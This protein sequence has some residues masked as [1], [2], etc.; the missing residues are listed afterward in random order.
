MTSDSQWQY[1]M[2][3]QRTIDAPPELAWRA[4]QE[5]Q[6]T[7][8]PIA[9]VLVGIRRLPARVTGRKKAL[10]GGTTL[11]EMAEKSHFGLLT[12]DA[13]KLLELSRIAR[14]W[15]LV[16]TDGPVMVD[17]ADFL[18]FDEPGWAKVLMHFD[19]IAEGTGTRV[20]AGTKVTTTDASARQKFSLYWAG[21]RPFAGLTRVAILSAIDKRAAALRAE[22]R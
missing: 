16:P 3:H 17:R 13:P 4:L 12:Q 22:N 5:V 2:S 21:I 7:D 14:F 8:I 11:F 1:E 20:V 10:A 19:F 15:E 18:A 9:R 6:V